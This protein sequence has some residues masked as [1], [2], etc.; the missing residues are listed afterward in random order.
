MRRVL[1]IFLIFPFF[2]FTLIW[3]LGTGKVDDATYYWVTFI[4]MVIYWLI[5]KI[6]GDY[7]FNLALFCMA[8]GAILSILGIQDIGEKILRL[9]LLF[10]TVGILGLFLSYFYKKDF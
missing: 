5:F 2:G 9:S 4:F 1:Q 6:N 8:I 10:W 7:Q 3:F